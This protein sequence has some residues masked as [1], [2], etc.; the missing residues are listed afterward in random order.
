MPFKV[1]SPRLYGFWS[2]SSFYVGLGLH[3]VLSPSWV[4]WGLGVTLKPRRVEPTPQ[5]PSQAVSSLKSSMWGK[6]LHLKAFCIIPESALQS[7]KDSSHLF[8]P[9]YL[10]TADYGV[11][12]QGS[13]LG[14]APSARG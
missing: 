9:I 7:E 5:I 11:Y 13:P 8:K 6:P 4:H 3:R 14:E 10:E 2:T 12:L 1:A